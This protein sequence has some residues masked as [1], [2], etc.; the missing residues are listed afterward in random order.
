MMSG[1]H[2]AGR[3]ARLF[4]RLAVIALLVTGGLA[5]DVASIAVT[6]PAYAHAYLLESSPVDGQVLDRTPA[7]VRLRFN[8]SVNLGQ[9]SIQL[10]DVTGK[11]LAIG[12]SDYSDGK[13]N[14]ARTILPPGLAE[15]T[16]VVAWRVTSADSHVVSGA[17][18]F[19]V[20]HPSSMAVPVEQD[21]DP[22]VPIVDAVG[23]GLAFLGVALVLGGALFVVV[24]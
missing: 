13:A 23:R 19:S 14:T 22:A 7:E 10:L 11:K 6:H 5:L 1:M 2:L 21:V 24:L 17:F 9:R 3:R 12:A 8:E 4:T 15:G 20:G 16:Y 18:S